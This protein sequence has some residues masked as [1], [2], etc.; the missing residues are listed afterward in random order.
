MPDEL[1]MNGG[2]PAIPAARPRMR[3]LAMAC[4]AIALI[5]GVLALGGPRAVWSQED[6]ACEVN[7]LGTIGTEGGSELPADG[8][9]TTE[10]CDSRF[11]TDSDAHTYSF[12]VVEGGRIRIDLTSAEGDSYLYLLAEDGSRITDNDDG[13]ADLDAR[14]ERD[15]APGV[16]L[17]EAT[18]VGGRG[19]GPVSFSL[20]ISRVTV[21]EPVH[22]GA[23]EPGVDLTASGSWTLDTCGSRFVVEH[24]AYSY[25]F[26]LSQ[27]SRVLIDLTSIHGDPVLSLAARPRII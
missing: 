1:Q 24:P 9:W 11:R 23:L 4:A 3:M 18:T 14:V 27:G 10:D 7:D 15:L 8:R 16:Y 6:S 20:S 17:V 5:A 13:G 19:R 12:E 25:S 21:C 2:R 26:N 22:L